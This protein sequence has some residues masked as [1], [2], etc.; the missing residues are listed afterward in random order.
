MTKRRAPRRDAMEARLEDAM[1]PGDFIPYAASGDFVSGLEEI[2]RR[3]ESIGHADPGRAVHLFDVFLAAC[4]EKAEEVD[5]SGGDLGG[6]VEALFGR[7]MKARQAADAD[8]DETARLLLVRM[9]DDP[10]GFAS[11]LE[12]EALKTLD[13]AALASLEQQVRIRFDSA[14]IADNHREATHT[15]RRWAE[16]LRSLVAHRRDVPGYLRLCEET[17][18]TPQDCVAVAKIL[19]SLRKPEEALSWVVRGLALSKEQPHG[20]QAES[21]LVKMKRELLARVGRGDDALTDAWTAFAEQPGRFSYED[22]MRFV[23]KAERAPWHVKAMEA[24]EHA[25]L[26]AHVELLLATK[27]TKRLVERLRRASDVELEELSH[28]KMGL[29]VKCLAKSHPGIAARLHR[30]LGMRILNAKK[31]RCY[32]AALGNFEDARACYE[33]AGLRHEW[34]ALVAEIRGAHRR[35]AGFIAGFDRLAEGRRPGAAPSFLERARTRW[36]AGDS[37]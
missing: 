21:E 30:A 32:D 19:R 12:R 33:R 7:W 17:E 22:L 9:D 2:A 24:A 28:Y 25:E 1:L 13:K 14:G 31:S 20:W 5:D 37:R 27:E 23:P 26:A 35:K 34:H 36:S 3:I 8:P 4:Y 16:V 6:F 15:R 29:A 10:Y 18:T 11:H